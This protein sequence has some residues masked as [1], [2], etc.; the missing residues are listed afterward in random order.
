VNRD[1]AEYWYNQRDLVLIAISFVAVDLMIL[2]KDMK[3]STAYTC[4]H[5]Y[6][7]LN[8]LATIAHFVLVSHFPDSGEGMPTPLPGPHVYKKKNKK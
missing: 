6:P 5:F 8:G 3:K 7:L 2:A 1:I 4:C